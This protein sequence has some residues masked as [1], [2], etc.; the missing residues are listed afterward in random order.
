MKKD[1]E[2]MK[3]YTCTHKKC[4]LE[5]RKGITLIGLVITIIVLLILAGVSVSM[6]LGENGVVTQA[7]NSKIEIR[8]AS[9]EERRDFWNVEKEKYVGTETKK[10]QTLSQLLESLKKDE[11]LTDKEIKEI[12][13]T[14]KVTIGSRTIIFEDMVDLGELYPEISKWIPIYTRDH[15]EIVGSGDT[16]TINGIE[17]K[18]EYGAG[19]GYILK[20]NIDLSGADFTSLPELT[21]GV[22]YGNNKKIKNM[23][24]N[25]S[26]D[27]IGLFKS[28]SGTISYLKL[29]NV[30][31]NGNSYS[32]IGGVTGK[33]TGTISY[34][35]VKHNSITGNYYVGGIIG[36]NRGGKI[37]YCSNAG[38]ISRK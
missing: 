12:N 5:D 23:T 10:A 30:N 22:F 2:T 21:M 20:D 13:E 8:G 38:S 16:R 25:G 15:L 36:W 27:Y 29:E 6:V 17:Y 19:I 34:V 28:N 9:V 14:G 1:L 4:N 31:I 24:V 7:S 26:N 32:Y 18:F 33:N 3:G 11:L 37:E 35:E